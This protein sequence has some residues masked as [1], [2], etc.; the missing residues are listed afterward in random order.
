MNISFNISELVAVSRAVS[1]LS[2]ASGPLLAQAKECSSAVD[3][4]SVVFCTPGVR[5]SEAVQAAV[6]CRLLN[7]IAPFEDRQEG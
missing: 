7:A 2:M 6:M 3:R 1:A 4:A 5:Y